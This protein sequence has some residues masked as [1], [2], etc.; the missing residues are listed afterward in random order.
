[1]ITSNSTTFSKSLTKKDLVEL[2]KDVGDDYLITLS[3][4][5]RKCGG[6]NC[7][8]QVAFDVD[9]V[10][11]INKG[12]TNNVKNEVIL[13]AKAKSRIE[14]DSEQRKRNEWV[15]GPNRGE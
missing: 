13:S 11:I 9:K 14:L 5:E 10:E 7:I 6:V 12:N 1:M 8:R 4:R 3:V 2:L 15:G